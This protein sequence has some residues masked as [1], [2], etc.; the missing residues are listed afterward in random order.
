MLSIGDKY[1]DY[2]VTG[3]IGRGGMGTVL[4][5]EKDGEKAALKILHPHLLD[6]EELVRR[7]YLEA[8]VAT[9]IKSDRICRVYDIRQ[10]S[11]GARDSHGILMEFVEGDALAEMMEQGDAFGEEWA[12]HVADGV[13]EGLE[14]IHD[15]GLLHRDIKPENII[16]TPEDTIKLLDLGL[17]K[18][19]ESSIKLSKTGYFI[20]TYHYASPEQLIGDDLDFSCDIYSLGTVLYELTTGAR[21]HTSTE[22]R[23]LI[24]EKINVPVRRPSRL[25]PTLSPFFDMLVTDMLQIKPEKRVGTAKLCRQII[26]ERERCDWY[27]A[28][29]SVSISLDSISQSTSLRRMVRVPRRTGLYGRSKELDNLRKWAGRAIGLIGDTE[30]TSEIR[31]GLTVLI[32]GEAGIGKTRLVEELVCELEAGDNPFVVL[33]GRS[34]QEKRHVPYGPLIEMV[35]DFFMLDNEPDVDLVQLFGEYLPNLRPLIPPFLELVTHKRFLDE[36]DIRGVLNETNLLHLFQTLFTTIAKEVPLI[37]FLD[38]LQWTDINTI[39]VLS[40]LATGIAEAPLLIIGTF[41]DE[42]LI[43]EDGQTHPLNEVIARFA[44]KPQ[45]KRI[46]LGRLDSDACYGIV[47]ECFPAADFV[48]ELAER[49]FEKSEGNPFYIIEILNLLFDEG[50]VGFVQGRWQMQGVS[51]DIEIPPSLREIVAYRLEKL[52][53]QEREILEAASILGYRFSSDL[54]GK[55][56]EIQRIKLLRTL[57]KLEKNRR[58]I[59][60]HEAGYRFDHHVVYE[61]VYDGIIPEL[62][63]EYHRSAADLLCDTDEIH[64]VVYSLVYH[65]R[66]AEED[67]RLLD[68]LPIACNRARSEYSNRLALEH[69]GWAW[70]AYERLGEPHELRGVVAKL[71]GE[72]SEVAGILGERDS[73]LESAVQMLALAED[74]H[75]IALISKA[76]RLLGEHARSISEWDQALS[77]YE[78]ALKYCPEPAGPECAAILRHMGAVFHLKGDEESA[79]KYYH[80]ALE[81]LENVPPSSELVLTHNNLGISLKRISELEGAIFEFERAQEIAIDIGDLHAET[82]PLGSLA[83]INYDAGRWEEAQELFVK[84]LNILEQTGDMTSRARTLL[85]VGNIYFQVGLYEQAEDYFIE[86]LN[87]RRRMEHRLGEAIVL[88]HLA[89]IDFERGEYSEA[90]GKLSEAMTIHQEIGDRRGEAGALAVLARVNNIEGRNKVALECASNALLIGEESGFSGR[91]IEAEMEALIARLE[92]EG[93]ND[94]ITHGVIALASDSTMKSFIRRGPRALMRLADLQQSAGLN[95]AASESR[96]IARTIVEGNLAHL[97]DPEWSASYRLI[98]QAILH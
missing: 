28:R 83:L 80:K 22:I 59:V 95:D 39:G 16:I 64:P 51:A 73:E 58:L 26:C 97:Q 3:Y 56:I 41:R 60:C 84:L 17:A 23:E 68:Y 38:D 36:S 14:A 67:R 27:K 44:G 61:T 7:F 34:L 35:R 57:Q 25:N 85:N 82:F 76:N 89:H 24:H 98:Y 79:I 72:R 29:V 10:V 92:L 12:L 1:L 65:L 48:D 94:T 46:S 45:V 90:L 49:V 96:S 13:L 71:L 52:S 77:R 32:G 63:T 81:A 18:V 4:L 21:P 31:Q 54:L 87:A 19:I 93:L 53:D 40:Y 11:L 78:L 86:S 50:K 62:R 33:A 88:H 15:A 69:A 70:D 55:L 9:R 8:E 37:L 47:S 74:L 75:D 30:S 6:D 43:A 66:R 5:L 42:E 20:G 2:T 91:L